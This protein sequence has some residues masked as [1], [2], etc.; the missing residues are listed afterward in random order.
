MK[1][2]KTLWEALLEGVQ[3]YQAYRLKN[4]TPYL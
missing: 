4:K 1:L 3:Q 2:L